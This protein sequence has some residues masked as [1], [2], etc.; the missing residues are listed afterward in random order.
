LSVMIGFA[1]VAV[2]A[3]AG[4]A[5]QSIGLPRPAQADRVAAD[6]EA[7]LNYHRFSID[8]FHSDDRRFRGACLRGWYA[9]LGRHRA[10]GS[11][12]VLRGG[13]VALAT[14]MGRIEFTAGR[15]RPEFPA[16]LAVASGCTASLANE[17]NA[18]WQSGLQLEVDRTYAAN[19]P[20]L[21]L[22]LPRIR[23]ERLVLYV[24]PRGY[25]PLVT[26]LALDGRNASARLYLARATPTREA[27][28]H[29]FLPRI[30]HGK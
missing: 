1:G 3:S 28:L 8:V 30:L 29:R 14:R 23:D 11:L 2:L 15:R 20:A 24:S 5:V 9:H 26:I 19:Q 16:S 18:A 22:R 6:A 13:P 7:W 25:K 4:W 27:N 17:L 12:L 21:A 10:R